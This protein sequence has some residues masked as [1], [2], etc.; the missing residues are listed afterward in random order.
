MNCCFTKPTKEP[1]HHHTNHNFSPHV[2]VLPLSHTSHRFSP[3]FHQVQKLCIFLHII[4]PHHLLFLYPPLCFLTPFSS[5]IDP[6]FM[7]C[8]KVTCIY[9]LYGFVLDNFWFY[10]P[11]SHTNSIQLLKYLTLELNR[12]F[13]PTFL[14]FV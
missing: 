8:V 10:R 13:P 1:C 4:V 3:E 2:G 6:L 12:D 5:F 11:E 14:S 7:G 9:G